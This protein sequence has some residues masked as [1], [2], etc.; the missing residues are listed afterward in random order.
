MLVV[1]GTAEIFTPIIES[2]AAAISAGIVIGGFV[3]ASNGTLRGL[4]RSEVGGTALRDSYAGAAWAAGFLGLRPLHRLRCMSM[5]EI[6]F[7]NVWVSLAIMLPIGAI[8]AF[9]LRDHPDARGMLG[10]GLLFCTIALRHFLDR[11]EFD[12]PDE[13]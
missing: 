2:A 9:L 8:G 12:G 11:H 3:G 6:S 13:D 1:L 4:S 5:G 7:R 10:F